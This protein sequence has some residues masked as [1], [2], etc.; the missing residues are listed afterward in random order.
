MDKQTQARLYYW[1]HCNHS[2]ITN[3]YYTD[4]RVYWSWE[5]MLQ[6]TSQ[7]LYYGRRLYNDRTKAN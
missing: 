7:E 2:D 3:H 6:R 4:R 1:T 5:R